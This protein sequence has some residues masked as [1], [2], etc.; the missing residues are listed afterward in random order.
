MKFSYVFFASVA[1]PLASSVVAS[2]ER[3]RTL[4]MSM[5]YTLGDVVSAKASKEDDV[6]GEET[7]AT[8]QKEFSMSMGAKAEKSMSLAPKATKL[9]KPAPSK[10][11]KGGSMPE[12]E[13]DSKSGKAQS[14]PSAKAEKE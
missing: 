2:P 1:A 11:D 5:S 12:D 10:A 9:F 13:A 3:L 7:A 6:P 8:E 4:Q 14:M